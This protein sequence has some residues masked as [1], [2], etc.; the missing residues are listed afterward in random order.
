MQADISLASE[1]AHALSL[2][3]YSN[4]GT[5]GGYVILTKEG[6]ACAADDDG[7]AAMTAVFGEGWE[8]SV[9][10]KYED[11]AMSGS[12]SSAVSPYTATIPGS[13]YLSNGNTPEKLLDQVSAITDTAAFLLGN[14][15]D[16][17]YSAVKDA[18]FENSANKDQ[19]MAALC[20]KFGIVADEN[21]FVNA[22][23]EQ[24]SNLLVFAV[25][26]QVTDV[27]HGNAQTNDFTKLVDEYA[28]C[29]AYA[30]ANPED[31]AIQA[32][33][34]KMNEELRN[35]GITSAMTTIS[36]FQQDPGYQS[37]KDGSSASTD[38]M[39]F[40]SMMYALNAVSGDVTAEEMAQENYFSNSDMISEQLNTYIS[41]A[42]LT[43]EMDEAATVAM[44][45]GGIIMYLCP[46]GNGFVIDCASSELYKS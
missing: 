38:K 2:Y 7:A 21:G 19:D 4:P 26:Q 42:E 24:I 33:Y 10:L 44:G 16:D 30:N 31:E 9:S 25:A 3:Y 40:H 23:D 11:W 15:T 22:T 1:V 27:D 46:N 37:Y 29:V 34:N 45:N 41:I 39:A 17:P 18:V 14:L 43:A 36:Q 35:G 13:S 32:Q 12:V 28:A 20:E 6:V 8:N 5:T